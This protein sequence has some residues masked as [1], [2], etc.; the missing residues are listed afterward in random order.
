MIRIGSLKMILL[1]GFMVWLIPFAVSI[2]IFPIKTSI[3]PLFE[4]IMPV[5]ITL[6][7]VLFSNL[8]FRRLDKGFL[9]EGVTLGVTWFVI[10]LVLDLMIF[11]EGPMKMSLVNY[12][13]DIGLTY[14]IIP[15][16]TIGS[17]YLID[18]KGEK[19]GV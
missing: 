8:Y 13:M 15:I 19:S 7:V 2:L 5:V 11:M 14:L 1:S 16:V 18:R 9:K 12:M 6:C 4:S 3:P 17:G 10:S